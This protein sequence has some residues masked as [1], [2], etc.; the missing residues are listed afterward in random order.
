MEASAK[1]DFTPVADN[2]EAGLIIRGNDKNHYDL[3]LTMRDGKRVAMMRQYL[4]DKEAGVS[5]ADLPEGDVVFSITSTPDEYKFWVNSADNG[6]RRLIGSAPT[7]NLSNEV[8]T[9]FTGVYI[10]MYASGNGKD[11]T[12]P[13]DFDWFEFKETGI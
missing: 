9:G 3:L 5:Y 13:A 10:A 12:N 4:D 2:E 11:N 6:D 7:K 1:I 8:I